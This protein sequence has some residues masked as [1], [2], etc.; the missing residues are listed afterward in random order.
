MSAI[1]NSTLLSIPEVASA[2]TAGES[3]FLAGS[4]A[5]LS[6]LPQGNWVGG[7]IP[8]FMSEDGGLLA[9][10]R[11]FVTKVPEVALEAKPADY[12]A[13][14][15]GNLYRDAPPNGFTFL[16]LPAA[17]E[18]HKNLPTERPT[19]PASC[20]GLWSVGSQAC[21]WTASASKRPLS[22][23]ASRE[24]ASQT[25]PWRC[26]SRYPPTGPSI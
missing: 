13:W 5:A 26:I 18:A 22:S 19:S 4:Q 14:E 20:C 15:L 7:T 25:G 24:S 9:E 16:I 3:L 10:D 23:T 8:Y 12:S 11:I 1:V 6:Q 21:A 17:S 2:I